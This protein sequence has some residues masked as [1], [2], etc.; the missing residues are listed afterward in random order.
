MIIMTDADTDGAH[1][2]TLLLTFFYRYM[3]D[4]IINK[5]VF[6]ALPPLYKLTFA[7]RKFIYLWD[8]Q[9]LA[10]YA[11]QRLKKYEIQRYKGLGEWMLINCEK[12]QWIQLNVNNCCNNWRCI[13]AKSFRTLMGE[14]K[15]NVKNEFKKTLNYIRR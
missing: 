7:D 11:K 15:K 2:Q 6:I 3:K 8:E 13:T 1:I 5:H 9:E 14:D 4:L 10:D 12:Q